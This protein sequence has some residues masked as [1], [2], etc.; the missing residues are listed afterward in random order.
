MRWG[1]SY[2]TAMQPEEHWRLFIAA[3]LP[4]EVVGSIARAQ[5]KLKSKLPAQ[6]VRWTRPEGIHLTL[7]FLGDTPANQVDA[8]LQKLA[9]AVRGQSPIHL[10][11]R[12]MGCFPTLARPRV[13]W[14]GLDGETERL[15]QIAVSIEKQLGPL[16]Y[17]GDRR[18]FSPHLTMGRTSDNIRRDELAL[19]RSLIQ[20]ADS[21][22]LAEWRADSIRLMRSHMLP[23]GT[24]YESLGTAILRG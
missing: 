24:Q 15:A 17:P 12:G 7:K 4:V 9:E 11:A 8:I 21:N 14:V 16:G 22:I 3:E 18:G 13:I 20:K 1:D 10:W 23:G 19:I 6:A 5:A 2:Q